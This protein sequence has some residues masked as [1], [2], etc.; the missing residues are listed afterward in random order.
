ME[1]FTQKW[2]IVSLLQ[3]A[4]DAD[5]FWK[6]WPLHVTLADV[7][8]IDWQQPGL[9]ER[10]ATLLSRQPVVE[11]TVTGELHWG[12]TEAME[13]AP[14]PRL[15]SLHRQLCELL[16]EYGA[17]FNQPQYVM[18]GYTPHSTIQKSG[19]LQIGQAVRLDQATII[20][21][22]PDGDGYQRRL[23]RRFEFGGAA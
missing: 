23:G 6:D 5:F 17:V 20:D 12:P 3:P 8:A 14:T 10:L 21:M 13:L 18:D 15:I 2:T 1:H 4:P 9:Q 16:L 11:S 19:R 7:F 22:F